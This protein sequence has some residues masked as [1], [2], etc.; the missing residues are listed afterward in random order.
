M[1]TTKDPAAANKALIKRFYEAFNER[2]AEAMV[3]CYA[4]GVVFRD[5]AFGEQRGQRAGDMWR[6]LCR[7]GRDLQVRA[8]GIRA[9][10]HQG[11]AHWEADY[12]FSTKRKVHN[13]VEARFLFNDGLIVEHTD[14]FD[15][16]RWA[17]QAFGPA[18]SLLGRVPYVPS[19]FQRLANRQLDQFQAKRGR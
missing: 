12:T 10:T 17:A 6:M 4:P 8:S 19:L 9:T 16:G 15:F 2:D 5:P 13:V 3:A 7:Q 14:D 11:S 18:G 1:N